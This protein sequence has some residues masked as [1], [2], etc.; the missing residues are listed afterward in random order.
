ML[1]QAVVD[2]NPAAMEAAQQPGFFAN[3]G[4]AISGAVS[5]LASIFPGVAV[6]T[7][8]AKAAEAVAKTQQK[9]AESQAKTAASQAAAAASEAEAARA[10][11]PIVVQ[12]AQTAKWVAPVL[13]VGGL[14]VGGYFLLRKKRK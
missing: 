10:R 4:S 8:E 2:T 6:A 1:G 12:A 14:A 3:I 7:L 5:S 9:V 11:Q 13:V